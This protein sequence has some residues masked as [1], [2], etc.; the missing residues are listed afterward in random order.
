VPPT[1]CS[2]GWIELKRVLGFTVLNPA[3]AAY[4]APLQ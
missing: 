3:H 4:P 2:P 1:P